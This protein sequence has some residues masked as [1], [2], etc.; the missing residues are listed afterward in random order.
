MEA[1]QL[2]SE[3]ARLLGDAGVEIV[4]ADPAVRRLSGTP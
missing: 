4:V 1:R 3:L 2:V